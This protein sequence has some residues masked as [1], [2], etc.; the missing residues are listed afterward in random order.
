MTPDEEF[1]K[2]WSDGKYDLYGF[3]TSMGVARSAYLAATKRTAQEC[4]EICDLEADLR[5][6]RQDQPL[7]GDNSLAQG[8]KAVTARHLAIAIKKRFGL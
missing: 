4:V 8:H 7:P 6:V 1:E 5:F 3:Q 2:F